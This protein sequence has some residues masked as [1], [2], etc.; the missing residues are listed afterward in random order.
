MFSTMNSNAYVFLNALHLRLLVL[1]HVQRNAAELNLLHQK[2]DFPQD[3]A[4]VDNKKSVNK[5]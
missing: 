4:Y 3:I 1:E 5:P 2:W